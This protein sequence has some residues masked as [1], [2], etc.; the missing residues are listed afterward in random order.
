MWKCPENADVLVHRYGGGGSHNLLL[1][2]D[3][4][5]GIVAFRDRVH[6]DSFAGHIEKLPESRDLED[7]MRTY[8]LLLPAGKGTSRFARVGMFCFKELFVH[9][10]RVKCTSYFCRH[11]EDVHISKAA[12]N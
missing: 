10:P 3:I 2:I 12:P 9:P 5:E 11:G 4:V 8:G 1:S 7:L 6:T